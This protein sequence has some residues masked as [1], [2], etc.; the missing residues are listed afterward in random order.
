VFFGAMTLGSTVWG[1]LATALSLPDAHFIAAAWALLGI[2]LSWRFKL[3]S[4]ATADLTPSEHWPTPSLALS[5]PLRWRYRRC[6]NANV[7]Q[8][9]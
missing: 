9:R 8:A 3:Q 2:P 6:D 7:R 5:A 4:S 1:Q